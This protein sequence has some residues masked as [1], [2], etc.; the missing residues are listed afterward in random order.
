MVSR[1]QGIGVVDSA[2]VYFVFA[3]TTSFR[4][5]LRICG[6]SHTAMGLRRGRERAVHALVGIRS[7]AA[8]CDQCKQL[9]ER[10]AHHQEMALHVLDRHTL[11]GIDV[12]IAK[13]GS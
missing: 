9:D 1:C 5:L 7:E 13:I 6:N 11:E 12:L 2:D 10:I 8:M 3:F 4:P